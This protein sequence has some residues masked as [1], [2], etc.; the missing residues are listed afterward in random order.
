ML[1]N[2]YQQ[3]LEATPVIDTAFTKIKGAESMDSSAFKD[4]VF[5]KGVSTKKI[6]KDNKTRT[7]ISKD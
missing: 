1:L 5:K 7:K 4:T 6:R 3:L 2:Q